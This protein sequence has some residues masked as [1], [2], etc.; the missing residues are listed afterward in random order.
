MFVPVTAMS[1]LAVLCAVIDGVQDVTPA[2]AIRACLAW[3]EK[4]VGGLIE[5][6][7]RQKVLNMAALHGRNGHN[8]HV[9]QVTKTADDSYPPGLKGNRKDEQKWAQAECNSLQQL[10]MR[11]RIELGMLLYALWIPHLSTFSTSQDSACLSQKCKF[12][13]ILPSQKCKF[14]CIL[15]ACNVP[16]V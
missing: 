3:L 14:R 9:Q 12:R 8:K 4:M 15:P 7:D 11:L 1:T 13:C 2:F 10:I 16:A 5:M 6:H